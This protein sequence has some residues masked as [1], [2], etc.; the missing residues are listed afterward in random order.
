MPR[1]RRDWRPAAA[2]AVVAAVAVSVVA[3]LVARGG[4]DPF[5][6]AAQSNGPAGAVVLDRG[7]R[8]RS[9]PRDAGVAQGWQA[10]RP[11][12]RAVSLPWVPNAAP[13]SG[14]AGVRNYRGGVGWYATRFQVRRQGHYSINF[15]SVSHYATVWLDGRRLGSHV[16]A[17]EPFEMRARLK[18]RSTH[19]LTVRADWRF[20]ELQRKRGWNRAWFNFGG[21][22]RPVTL[23]RIGYSQP[24]QPRIWTH[25]V[26]IPGG[27]R[28]ALVSVQVRVRNNST[29]RRIA[30]V[31]TLRRHGAR[32]PVRFPGATVR[33]GGTHLFQGAATVADPELWSPGKPA[34]YDLRVEV[35]GESAVTA[36]VGLRELRRR[37]ALLYLNGRR[38]VLQ[39]ASLPPDAQGHGDGL[40]TADQAKIVQEL[41]QVGANATRAQQRI[42]PAL[43]DRLDAAGIL[44]WQEIGPFDAAGDW[45]SNTPALQRRARQRAI[46][47]FAELQ[48][49]PSIVAWSLANEIAGQGHPGGQPEHVQ[50]LTAQLH[51]LDPDRLVAVDLWGR[52]GP[53]FAGPLYAGLDAIGF[54]DYHGW[55]ESPGASGATLRD[56]VARRERTLRSI[57]PDKVLVVTEFGAAANS[58]NPP[59]AIGGTRYQADVLAEHVRAYRALPDLSGML[60]W[61]LRDYALT[62]SFTGGSFARVVPGVRLT[63]GL[64]EK[65]LFTYS[66]RAKPAA[67]VVRRAFA[68]RLPSP[69]PG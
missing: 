41:K 39:G 55:Y 62:P 18:A 20:P 35:A 48:S 11:T 22:N 56:L 17:Y 4:G 58:L 47:A 63:A 46:D 24:A 2:W 32:I 65:G 31:A 51:E 59:S 54:T 67:A 37:G 34:L 9:D 23:E 21:I 64:N 60:V 3:I 68:G 43:L 66:G 44:V 10:S 26:R 50:A 25:L 69:A 30:P 16:G 33:A 28:G 61:S 27:G 19:V 42:D 6:V 57:F 5:P 13:V 1:P 38:L 49:H 45:T 8:Y 40:T 15:G 52:H 7:W 36:R 29:T 14:P 53:H 12:G